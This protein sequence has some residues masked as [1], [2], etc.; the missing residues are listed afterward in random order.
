M[1]SHF[2]FSQVTFQKTYGGTLGDNANSFVKTADNN[3]VIVGNTSSFGVKP[4]A[5]D[6]YLIKVDTIGRLLWTKT[7][8][9]QYGEDGR[10]LQQ[11]S[12]GGYIIIG[13]TND[14]SSGDYN[15]YLIKTDDKGNLQWSEILGGPSTDEGNDIQQTIDGGYIIAGR[16]ASYGSGNSDGYILKTN[17]NGNL[18]WQYNYQ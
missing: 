3:Y 16:T 7:F 2:C 18:Q 15:I 1:L 12:D 10:T 9:G 17:A 13:T 5:T 8:G 6:V 14:F 4:G 11:T